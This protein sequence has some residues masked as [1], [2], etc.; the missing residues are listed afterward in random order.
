VTIDLHVH[1]SASDGTQTPAEVVAAAA[2]AGMGTIALTDHDTTAGW[3]D[4]LEA[5]REHGIGLIPGIELSCAVDGI[6]VHMLAY[7]PDPDDVVLGRMMHQVRDDRL[8]RLRT[9]V[10]RI[11][12]DHDLVWDDVMAAVGTAGG[13]AATVG[14]PHLADALVA[15][16]LVAD[17]DEAFATL[18]HR[19][20]PYYAYHYAP[21]A[22]ELVA[23]VVDAGGAPVIAHPRAGLRGR[24]LSDQQLAS[25]V[26]A[27]MAGVEVDHRDH[28]PADRRDLRDLAVRL[29]VFTTGSSDYHGAGKPN[30][31][32][33]NV[34][35]AES[36][37]RLLTLGR[38]TKAY[39]P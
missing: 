28:S 26:A 2:V 19:G 16:G 37:D 21:E 34:T 8:R 39:L 36:L 18:L 5:A 32:G 20:S 11:A 24:I 31:L 17:R 13:V 25:L 6:G 27:G 35:S 29:G 3:A 14:R 33:E 23:A 22:H 38:G 1:S 12:E 15:K 4:A 9:M 30:V 10:A 7:L